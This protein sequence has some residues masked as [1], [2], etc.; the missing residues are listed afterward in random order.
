[1]PYSVSRRPAAI[2]KTK[3]GSFGASSGFTTIVKSIAATNTAASKPATVKTAI[4]TARANPG[5][6]VISAVK[7]AV[8]SAPAIAAKITKTHT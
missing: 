2:D 7:T 6:S 8:A 4:A 5:F 1:M 3:H